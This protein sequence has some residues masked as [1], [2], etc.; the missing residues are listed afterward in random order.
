MCTYDDKSNK[1]YMSLNF[2]EAVQEFA[3]DEMVHLI[4]NS[5]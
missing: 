1:S 5:A 2:A 3:P 4:T